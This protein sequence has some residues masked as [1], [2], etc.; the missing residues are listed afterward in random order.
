M[1]I[2]ETIYAK[3]Q[4]HAISEESVNFREIPHFREN[5]KASLFQLYSYMM[6]LVQN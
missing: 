2:I 1:V 6:R 4:F 3:S 5:E